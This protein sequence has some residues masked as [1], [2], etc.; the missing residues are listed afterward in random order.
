MNDDH[1]ST[2]CQGQK[3]LLCLVI[4]YYLVFVKCSTNPRLALALKRHNTNIIVEKRD[5]FLQSYFPFWVSFSLMSRKVLG[6]KFA[7]NWEDNGYGIEIITDL[8]K[9]RLF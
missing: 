4:Q 7:I 5:Q 2:M 9:L 1:L 3:S 8:C 6:R